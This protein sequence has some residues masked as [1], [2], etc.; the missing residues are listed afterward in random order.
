MNTKKFDEVGSKLNVDS[1]GLKHRKINTL[2]KYIFY[3]VSQV[4][5]LGI[6]AILGLFFGLLYTNELS[7]NYSGYPFAVI[8]LQAYHYGGLISVGVIN[9]TNGIV[10]LSSH[11][12]K[13]K[14]IFKVFVLIGI[15]ALAA[16]LYDLLFNL[17]IRSSAITTASIRYG[18]FS[19]SSKLKKRD[20][21]V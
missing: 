18:V 6:S 8:S 21:H 4:F 2:F 3:P 19:G 11:K 1:S 12:I 16:Y 7:R 13:H 9:A 20:L 5:I 15:F 17:M 14:I 10:V